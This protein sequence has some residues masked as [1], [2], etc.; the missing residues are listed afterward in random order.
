MTKVRP[1]EF[2]VDRLSNQFP[3]IGTIVFSVFVHQ[4]FDSVNYF[5]RIRHLR[6]L[7][8]L[9]PCDKGVSVREHGDVVAF[10]ED[11]LG[12]ASVAVFPSTVHQQGI[13]TSQYIQVAVKELLMVNVLMVHKGRVGYRTYHG[14]PQLP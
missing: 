12:T 14:E 13:A 9:A 5:F 7:A 2:L 4:L 1:W 3:F 6:L 11:L 10:G 8:L